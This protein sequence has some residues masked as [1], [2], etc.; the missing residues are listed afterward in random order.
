MPTAVKTK[1]FCLAVEN[2][3]LSEVKMLPR[4]PKDIPIILI[5]KKDSKEKIKKF[6]CRR[7]KLIA[8]LCCLIFEYDCPAYQ[9]VEMPDI[10]EDLW[11]YI[12]SKKLWETK[13]LTLP[14][15]I[16]ENSRLKKFPQ[17]GYITPE[18]VIDEEDKDFVKDFQNMKFFEDS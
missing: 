2:Q 15:K 12:K 5:Q 18:K 14:L 16:P 17:N 8:M 3:L 1:G 6:A 4:L 13:N 10:T 7:N 9:N 11:E